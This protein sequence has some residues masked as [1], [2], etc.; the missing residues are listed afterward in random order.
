MRIAPR[1]ISSQRRGFFRS[2]GRCGATASELAPLPAHETGSGSACSCRAF[3]EFIGVVSA[4]HW[5]SA[6]K[7]S[8][9][10]GETE[11][12]WANRRN[13]SPGGTRTRAGSVQ[14]LSSACPFGTPANASVY[15]HMLLT[16]R[17]LMFEKMSVGVRKIT[18][19]LTISSDSAATMNV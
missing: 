1:E 9:T 15:R 13:T 8:F 3:E 5:Q 11:P 10:Y 17:I 19:G 2:R 12:L 7:I 4:S 6:Y 16:T 18:S 14:R